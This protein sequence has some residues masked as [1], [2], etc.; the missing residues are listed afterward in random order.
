ML[1]MPP[2]APSA[3]RLLSG[4]LTAKM[5]RLASPLKELPAEGLEPT[6]ILT[7]SFDEV[8]PRSRPLATPMP[9][10]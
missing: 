6:E 9:I 3:L 2:A 4:L 5:L 7:A 1:S 10:V 8:L